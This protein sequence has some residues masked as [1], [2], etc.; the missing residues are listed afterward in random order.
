MEI[1][2][3]DCTFSVPLVTGLQHLSFEYVSTIFRRESSSYEPVFEN[4]NM[5]IM[6]GTV[7]VFLGPCKGI[8]QLLRCISLKSQ[9]G[10]FSGEILF[11]KDSRS[12]GHHKDIVFI[13]KFPDMHFGSLSVFDFVLYS[14]QLRVSYD[15][16]ECRER[17]R[18]V[19]K[20]VGISGTSMVAI[21]GKGEQRLLSIAIELI[22]N[23]SLI[24]LNDPLG[25]LDSGS[26]IIVMHVLHSLS[27]RSSNPTTIVY[28][29]KGIDRDMSKFI[30]NLA[31][32]DHRTLLW[33]G[34]LGEYSDDGRQRIMDS[35]SEMSVILKHFKDMTATNERNSIYLSL[36]K[37]VE[38]NILSAVK[39]IQEIPT[40]NMIFSG[41]THSTS[42]RKVSSERNSEAP[43]TD[44]GDWDTWPS[45]SISSKTSTS[46]SFGIESSNERTFSY[47]Q[48]RYFGST[49]SRNSSQPAVNK[50]N[51]L[52]AHD[53]INASLEFRCRK[54]IL[55]E[56]QILVSRSFFHH[57][58]YWIQIRMSIV[59]YLLAG[60]LI[61]A[62]SAYDGNHLDDNNLTT[63]N[64]GLVN[65]FAY[66]STSVLFLIAVM[67][68]IGTSFSVTYI[69]SSVHNLKREVED[70]LYR[71]ASG[72][73]AMVLVD[74][75]MYLIASILFG[76]AI[77]SMLGIPSSLSINNFLSSYF[78][79]VVLVSLS[80][81][82]LAALCAVWSSSQ[83]T[84]VHYFSLFGFFC[85]IFTGYLQH[86]QDLPFG[87]EWA[88][89]VVFTRFAFESLML[90]LFQDV[91][92]GESYLSTFNFS[93]GSIEVCIGLLLMWFFLL[94]VLFIL[95]ILPVSN[96]IK[97]LWRGNL[98]LFD[99]VLTG[100]PQSYDSNDI[101][102][103]REFSISKH[104]DPFR[105][106]PIS[107][108][109][110]SDILF[111]R[112]KF[113]NQ[114]IGASGQESG[115]A[116]FQNVFGD[117]PAGS[118][119]CI[120]DV[121]P[122]GIVGRMLLQVLAGRGH[123]FGKVSGLLCVNGTRI[124]KNS[125]LRNSVYIGAG[126]VGNV[127]ALTVKDAIRFSAI[128][129]CPHLVE[130][131]TSSS[132]LSIFQAKEK[133]KGHSILDDQQI[134]SNTMHG[135]SSSESGHRLLDELVDEILAI[136]GLEYLG[137]EIVGPH[138]DRPGLSPGQLRCLTIAVELVT[139]PSII[140]I[141]DLTKALDVFDAL[142][143]AKAVNNLAKGHR[144]VL[145]TLSFPTDNII[146]Y[147]SHMTLFSSSYMIYSG[148]LSKAPEYF[149]SIGN[150]LWC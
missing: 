56:I 31:L 93:N 97:T 95:G 69:F 119:A 114:V 142:L 62:M 35:I 135:I 58:K 137:D 148:Q 83:A 38:K 124:G 39:D 130:K 13:S 123:Q 131:S 24:V 80:G 89:S 121:S 14:C 50:S 141:E 18:H 79:V 77:I 4:V 6:P 16:I 42:S 126:D 44:D 28:D 67:S 136:M 70:G 74:F 111:Q 61:G 9:E 105:N 139:R 45:E 140:F 59:R 30:D 23:P 104:C 134:M 138:N 15:I 98:H 146:S 143:V 72:Y 49:L 132:L 128:L 87:W 120:I 133:S 84:S 51:I 129:R 106:I 81:Y 144:T 54:T 100:E 76:A 65:S 109:E 37:D 29:T 92:D 145:S 118:C 103:R 40:R 22:S 108:S 99:I 91:S 85:I 57:I 12:I 60:L 20:L 117:F 125:K 19:L 55:K 10:V 90:S 46:S 66:N 1:V 64:N 27:R 5:A 11:N 73:I 147:F 116:V 112:L 7:N 110:K 3:K 96:K 71:T 127:D 88:S 149:E 63:S 25:G 2:I 68:I 21:L 82:S 34:A 36:R 113:V 48:R 122:S 101:E 43:G 8:K 150:D 33:N 17:S 107:S 94:Q 102:N 26:A 86:I 115:D 52:K 75:L 41:L 32:F 53:Q 78:S 47:D